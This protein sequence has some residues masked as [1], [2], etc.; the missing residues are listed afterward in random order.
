MFFRNPLIL[1]LFLAVAMTAPSWERARGQ[2][3]DEALKDRRRLGAEGAVNVALA[4][5]TKHAIVAGPNVTVRG[6]SM[7]DEQEFELALEEFEEVA[8][9]AFGRLSHADREDDEAI[10][11]A[12]VRA[13]RKAADRLWSKRP[14]VDVT[15][16]RI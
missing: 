11:S 6:L 7:P 10:E 13:V 14:L 15:V 16:L 9:A 8:D 3:S 5:N 12:L 2:G 1:S 4:V